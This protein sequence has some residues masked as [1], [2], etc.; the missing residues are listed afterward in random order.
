[1]SDPTARV[2]IRLEG[3]HKSFGSQHVL[4]GLDL[5]VMM[6]KVNVVIGLSGAGKSVLL[7]LIMGLIPLDAGRVLVHGEDIAALNARAAR[8]MRSRFGL[9]FQNGALFDSM[10]VFENVAF[11]LRE[12]TKMGEAE[13]RSRVMECLAP[14]GLETYTDKMPGDLSG[15]MRKRA[16]LARALVR[17]PEFILYDEPTT[18]LDPIRCAAI[19]QLIIDTNN[20]REGLTSL[21]IS[22]DMSGVFKIADHVSMLHHGKIIAAGAPDDF[23]KIEDARVQQFINGHREGP[24]SD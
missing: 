1:V 15:G 5:D 22:H 16:S 7:K 19:D 24:I 14:V 6:G 9:V 17:T 20:S 8:R 10:T 3:L 21:V 18:G 11:P 12:H 2:A 23:I 4:Q 13:I